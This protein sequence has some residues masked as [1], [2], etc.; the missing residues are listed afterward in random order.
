MK[1]RTLPIYFY[2]FFFIAVGFVLIIGAQAKDQKMVVGNT[3]VNAPPKIVYE[4]IC[5]YRNCP[6]A[7]RKQLST[8]PDGG[9]VKENMQGVAVLGNV[10]VIWKEI[11]IPYTHVDYSMISSDKFTTA[12]GSW[13]ITPAN[14]GKSTN[15]E[16]QAFIKADVNI[17]FAAEITRSNTTKDVRGRLAT[18]KQTAE[19]MVSKAAV[20]QTIAVKSK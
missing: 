1:N 19:A 2:L 16:L 17:P 13:T 12:F 4:A 14:G 7:H 10:Q 15:L 20:S 9:T 11:G 3:V 5:Q 18:I 8:S 6:S